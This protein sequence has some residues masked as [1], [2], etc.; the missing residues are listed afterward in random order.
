MSTLIPLCWF[1]QHLNK[2]LGK[3]VQKALINQNKPI[4]K[5]VMSLSM[6]ITLNG[7]ITQ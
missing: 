2:G 4:K 5:C 6:S 7:P 3:Q 1:E